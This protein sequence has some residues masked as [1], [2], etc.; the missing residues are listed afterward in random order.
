MIILEVKRY[1]NNEGWSSWI[2]VYTFCEDT[3][4]NPRLEALKE[5]EKIKSKPA[6]IWRVIRDDGRL[7]IEQR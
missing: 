2:P 5:F 6:E 7:I 3:C 1:V 4:K